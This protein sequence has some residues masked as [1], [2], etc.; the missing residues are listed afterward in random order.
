MIAVAPVLDRKSSKARAERAWRLRCAGRTWQEIAD[1]TGFKSRQAALLAVD[2]LLK[3]DPPE[4]VST[5]RRYT[6]E[7]YR[8]VQAALFESLAT[9]K[10]R[11]DVH[12]T[13]AVSRALTDVM[14]RR[15]KLLGLHVPVV[16]E[17]NLT[18]QQSAS[19]VLDR[20]EAEL[21]AIA[22]G[23]PAPVPVQASLPILDAEVIPQ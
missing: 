15:A 9:A 13:V 11:K 16:Q 5:Q 8:I 17:V 20:A 4:D 6:A 12:A 2:R 7:G 23:Q 14:D 3:R 1:A 19:A 10:D 22:A 21:L 18:L